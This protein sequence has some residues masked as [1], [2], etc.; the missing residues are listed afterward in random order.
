MNLEDW[1]NQNHP[2]ILDEFNKDWNA[3]FMPEEL[4]EWLE[5]LYP[6]IFNEYIKTGIYM[7]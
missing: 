7:L 5:L 6:D 1:I 2:E 3:W 4:E